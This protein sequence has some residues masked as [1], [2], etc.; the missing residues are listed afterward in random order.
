MTQ[1]SFFL[2][3]NILRVWSYLRVRR[4]NVVDDDGDGDDDD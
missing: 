3:Q 1:N 2:F 4:L